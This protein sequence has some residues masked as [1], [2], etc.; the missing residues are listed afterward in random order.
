LEIGQS[1]W[2]IIASET[3]QARVKSKSP[4]ET[5]AGTRTVLL[6]ISSQLDSIPWSFGQTVEIRF[7]VPTDNSGYWVPLTALNREATGLWSIFV[8]EPASNAETATAEN[9]QTRAARKMVELV[10]LEDDWALVRGAL[11]DNQAVIVNG[12]HRIVPGQQV[13]PND[14]TDDYTRPDALGA[15]E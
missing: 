8:A 2:I 4:N 15:D 13:E 11:S 9:P 5:P 6:Q 12:S 1:V 7:F 10:Q 3:A 14:I